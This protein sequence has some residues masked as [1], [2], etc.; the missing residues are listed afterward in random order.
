MRSFSLCCSSYGKAKKFHFS[1][2]KMIL[3]PQQAAVLSLFGMKYFIKKL[4]F[5]GKNKTFNLLLGVN[6]CL[7]HTGDQTGFLMAYWTLLAIKVIQDDL[8]NTKYILKI[9]RR[10][11][12]FSFPS[13]PCLYNTQPHAH[14]TQDRLL[15][16]LEQAGF[17]IFIQQNVRTNLSAL[18]FHLVRLMKLQKPSTTW[19]H[20]PPASK[21]H[22]C[23]R[24]TVHPPGGMRKCHRQTHLCA[25]P[26][27]WGRL[28]GAA[29]GGW[30]KLC[31]PMCPGSQSLQQS[32]YEPGRRPSHLVWTGKHREDV[33]CSTNNFA[34]WFLA[35][36]PRVHLLDSVQAALPP[37]TSLWTI[38][39]L[40]EPRFFHSFALA[41]CMTTADAGKLYAFTKVLPQQ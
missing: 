34:H 36:S 4:A 41:A 19:A 33:C 7:Q 37:A 35:R 32:R 40:W 27:C 15:V 17:I 11:K 39:K 9:L 25:L 30:K 16:H 14:K 13:H 24:R 38:T 2:E 31:S 12:V 21:V 5:I 8:K 10:N 3:I 23:F 26:S 29:C 6:K 28:G 1:E 18:G 20:D 22:A